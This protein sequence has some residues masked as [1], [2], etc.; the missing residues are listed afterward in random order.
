VETLLSSPLV[1]F[2]GYAVFLLLAVSGTVAIA[3]SLVARTLPAR[4]LA[5]LNEFD[6][7]L[8]GVERA[9]ISM[10]NEWAQM[11]EEMDSFE[12]TIERKR[13]QLSSAAGRLERAEGIPGNSESVGNVES[14]EQI[15]AR[16]YGKTN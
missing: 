2:V 5:K 4:V 6:E 9:A 15:R 13:K 11:I 14:I 8:A 3:T 10:R 7:R 1:P 16:I 12:T